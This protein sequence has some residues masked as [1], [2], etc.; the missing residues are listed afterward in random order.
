MP[1]LETPIGLLKWKG[2]LTERTL[3]TMPD[4]S[5]RH[6]YSIISH[7]HGEALRWLADQQN[8]AILVK[9]GRDQVDRALQYLDELPDVEPG[10]LGSPWP[11][12]SRP[13]LEDEAWR[14]S[15]IVAVEI[16]ELTATQQYLK[17][18]RVEYYVMNPGAIEPGK[19]ALA[20]VYDDGSELL[21]VDGH[22]RLAAWWILGVNLANV[23]MLHES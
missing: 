21:I 6:W 17:R 1:A 16:S 7:T 12:S 20:N 3:V 5:K 23:W 13:K 14:E 10:L 8:K 11:V 2:R 4:G 9:A 19:R 18:A 15:V 22:H